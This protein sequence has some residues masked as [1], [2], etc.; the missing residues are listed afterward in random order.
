MKRIAL[1]ALTLFALSSIPA[2]AQ[3]MPG[4]A[5]MSKEIL[6]VWEGPYQSDQVPP[7]SLRL[8]VAQEGQ[9]WKVTL[10]V[11][12]DQAPGS[13]EVRDFKVEGDQITWAQ[14]V[15]DFDCLNRGTVAGG[16]LK[17]TAECSQNGAV[18][19][20]ASYILEKKKT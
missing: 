20:T 7:G 12:T 18:A 5:D 10:E 16:I 4:K 2:T 13:G 6:G 15:G 17:G 19:L 1:F 14:T 8:T 3:Q 11:I 9:V